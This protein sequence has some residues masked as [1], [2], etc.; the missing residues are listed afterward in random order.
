MSD[1]F[2]LCQNDYVE[3][4][5]YWISTSVSR[6][7]RDSIFG[8]T[9]QYGML[10]DLVDNLKPLDLLKQR[11]S[12]TISATG[13]S[14]EVESSCEDELDCDVSDCDAEDERRRLLRLRT[15]AFLFCHVLP[16]LIGT[17]G[18]S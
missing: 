9:F 3:R 1:Q 2:R 11:R 14:E 10:V 6:I 12:P 8:A 16:F 15:A 7:N 18:N 5:R 4:N 13:G 17:V